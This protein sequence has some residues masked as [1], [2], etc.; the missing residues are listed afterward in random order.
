MSDKII[1]CLT[2]EIESKPADCGYSICFR[3]DNDFDPS[4][5]RIE[6][7]RDRV[8]KAV[9][10]TTDA[11]F[12]TDRKDMI[13][14]FVMEMKDINADYPEYVIG[15]HDGVPAVQ[16]QTVAGEK[17]EIEMMGSFD[18]ERDIAYL[19]RPPS[20]NGAMGSGCGGFGLA[21]REDFQFYGM[22][23]AGPALILPKR[24]APKPPR[25]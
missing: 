14:A 22:V 9:Y 1:L 15:S 4:S 25:R 13:E 19:R 12:T 10:A 20:A 23:T 5:D 2:I 11:P 21:A 8:S 17:L 18:P 7:W 3:T 16:I 24:P 6:A